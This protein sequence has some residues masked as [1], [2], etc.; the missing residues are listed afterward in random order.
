M[1]FPLSWL[2]E[3]IDL[4]LTPSGIA[5][6]LTSSGI[7]VDA[8]TTLSNETSH[9][10]TLFEISLTPNLGYCACLL[11]IA[12]ELS[13]VTERPVKVP[14]S[15]VEESAKEQIAKMLRVTV[16]D[17]MGSPRYA[18]RVIRG[19]TVGPS[20]EWL[21][22]RLEV[23]G[24][25]SVNNIVDITNYVLLETGQPLHAFDYDLLEGHEIVVRNAKEGEGFV[26]LDGKER[27][28]SSED[29]LICDKSKPVALAGVMGGLNSEVSDT[30][31]NVVLESAY[32]HPGTIRK[33]S[34][35][36][37]LQTD[38]SKRFERGC[39]PNQVPKALDRAIMLIKQVAGGD[40]L[41]GA[42]DIK[43]STFPERVVA[44]RLSRVNHILGTHISV[45]EVETIFKNL[46]FNY[47]WDGQDTFTVTVPTYRV[48]VL[49]EID[50]IEEVARIF[51]YDNIEKPSSARYHA[52]RIPH[53]PIF[54]FEQE[55]RSRMV[56]EG[57]QEFI[58]CDLIGPS[59]LGIVHDSMIPEAALIRVL[60]PTS[61]EQSV[62]RTSLLPGLL[63]V[64]KYN[65]DHQNL[66]VSGFEVGRVHFKDLDKYKEQ[67]VLGII[68]T[69]RSSPHHW[70]IKPHEIDFFEL[71]GMIENLLKELGIDNMTFRPS[72]YPTLHSGRQAS[73]FVDAL[74]LGSFGE[75]HPAIRRRLD[76]TQRIFFAEL[77]LHDLMQVRKVNLPMHDLPIYPSSERDW[78]ITLKEEISMQDLLA[79][80]RSAASPLLE[81]V[82]LVDIYRSEKLGKGLKNV[83]F[84]F[85][86]RDN[87]KTIE[88]EAVEA[89]HKHIINRVVSSLSA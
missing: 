79:T 2:Q 77:S 75:V 42:F 21:K 49:D 86:Y 25:R 41:E 8:V 31:R 14:K 47:R 81:Q 83:T 43:E 66:N 62:L 22:R 6:A 28:L 18:C 30:T 56:S 15:V 89:E 45:N 85:V 58:T 16:N 64:V 76:V 20:P 1:K 57:L 74:E 39:D 68:L 78:T 51:R 82:S 26:T 61:V 80:I 52:S 69:G 53:A 27:R 60:N 71:K 46:G 37:G 12:R 84:R 70:N 87:I 13:A 72:T 36:L 67:P 4:S 32:F 7:E 35:R 11:G 48:D 73:I 34:K 65:L 3:Y 24:L 63:Q 88:Q 44:C 10:D 29:L 55:V 38:A 9:P 59:L 50:L 19:V 5:S 33:T 23:C 17:R 40:I 54:H